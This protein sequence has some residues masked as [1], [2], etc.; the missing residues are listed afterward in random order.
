MVLGIGGRFAG[1][2]GMVAVPDLSNKTPDEAL[3]LLQ[4][5]GLKRSGLGS[6][7]TSNSALNNKVFQQSIAPGYL[8]DYESSIS[9][10]YYVYVAPAAPT[11][12]L[13]G[14]WYQ[15]QRAGGNECV[16]GEGYVEYVWL[17]NR[18]DYC[19]SGVP[20]GDYVVDPNSVVKYYPSAQVKY[21]SGI[22]GCC[23]PTCQP[24]WTAVSGSRTCGSC[25]GGTKTTTVTYKNSCDGTTEL[26]TSNISCCASIGCGS[27]YKVST[28]TWTYEYRK[29]C[30]KDDGA[31]NS[32]GGGCVDYTVVVSSGCVAHCDIWRDVTSCVANKCSPSS[33][34]QSQK[35]Q[36]SDC[37]YYYNYR[38]VLCPC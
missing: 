2:K 18:K 10:D 21:A 38:T 32:A 29:D 16:G 1:A 5:A 31:C 28:G 6:S 26:R 34:Q 23:T 30:K 22:C 12:Y 13:C 33:K 4:A 37:S 9:Y 25:S 3:A 17:E 11:P 8:V 20:T 27:Q 14:D 7:N 35:C 15:A 19:L 24:T 36:A